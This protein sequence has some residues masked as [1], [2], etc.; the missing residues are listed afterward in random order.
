MKV[1]VLIIITMCLVLIAGCSSPEKE[2]VV[3]VLDPSI[4]KTIPIVADVW[5]PF[6]E[7]VISPDGEYLLA[8]RY[9]FLSPTT[10]ILAIPLTDDS[11]EIIEMTS[12]EREWVMNNFFEYNPIGWISDNECIF[13]AFG[14]QPAGPN[15]GERGLAIFIGNPEIHDS[16][17]QVG[18]MEFPP[19]S[20]VFKSAIL[21]PEQE[22]LFIHISSQIWEFDTGNRE[23][24][25]I[26]DGLPIYDGLFFPKLSPTGEY[27]VYQIHEENQEGIYILDTA[28]GTQR[29]LLPSGDNMYFHPTWSPDGQYIAA[30]CVSR[31]RGHTGTG[32]WEYNVLEGED[33]PQPAGDSIAVFDVQGNKIAG[34][35]VENHLVSNFRWAQNSGSLAF[36]AGS[37]GESRYPGEKWLNIESVW[38]GDILNVTTKLAELN[39]NG[40]DSMPLWIYPAA[41]NYQGNGLYYEIYTEDGPELWYTSTTQPA[42]K[43]L[44]GSWH[45]PALEP[46]YDQWIAAVVSSG[47][48]IQFC[49]LNDTEIRIIPIEPEERESYLTVLGH[50]QDTFVLLDSYMEEDRCNA[51]IFQMYQTAQY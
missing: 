43:I 16:T 28:T 22:K 45:A 36:F 37:P 17:E 42:S 21:I 40:K 4:K 29:P 47:E 27:Y 41:I 31:K 23:L 46:F 48:K 44:D 11:A 50:N 30:Y 5:T 1:R 14:W 9:A 26:K 24:S 51:V 18:F 15:K 3:M 2:P 20:G 38:L 35:T 10:S 19:D 6:N 34:F 12:A 13:T 8:L 32:W 39:T 33:G 49:L 25:L 7:Q